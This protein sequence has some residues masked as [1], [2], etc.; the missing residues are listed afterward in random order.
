MHRS[1][2]KV[3]FVA[4]LAIFALSAMVA[5]SASAAW[6]INGTKLAAGKT[7]AL[8]NTAA[9]DTSTVL[10][11]PSLGIRITC[12][13][14]TLNGKEALIQGEAYGS[15][16]SLTFTECSEIAPSTC[17]IQSEVETLPVVASV[18]TGTKPLDRIRFVPKTGKTFATLVFKGT[19][20]E[21]GEQPINGQLVADAQTGQNESTTQPLEGLGTTE[22]NSLELFKAKAYLVGGKA[23]LKLA[24]GL[25]WSFH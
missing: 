2:G 17:T 4:L 10:S 23:L 18:E 25:A 21:S 16:T 1:K 19:C 24:S 14:K 9:V 6:F 12:S 5:S 11:A 8:A 7:V 13:G 22:N 3:A 20:A 15:A